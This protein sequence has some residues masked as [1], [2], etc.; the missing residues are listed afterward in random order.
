MAEVSE[1]R[2][3][4]AYHAGQ[5]AAMAG[6][7]REKCNRQPGTIYFDDWHDGFNSGEALS[8]A[9]QLKDHPHA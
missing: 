4:L 1:H 3:H 2:R 7:S 6:K 9:R 8:L 5:V